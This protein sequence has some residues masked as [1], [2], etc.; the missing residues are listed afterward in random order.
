MIKT[1]ELP[2]VGEFVIIKIS[3]IMPHGAYCRITEYNIDSYLPI[4]EVSSG[5][6]KNIHEFIKEGQQ[7]VAK[8]IFTD[9]EKKSVDIS[10]K[11]A[12]SKAKKDKINE[13][14][15]EKRAEGMFNKA[16]ISSKSED[17]KQAIIEELSKLATTYNEIINSISDGK[18]PLAGIQEKDFKSALYELVAK[19][20]KPK[21]YT[22]SYNV[23]LTTTDTKSGIN[24]IKEALSGIEKAG[25]EVLYMGAPKYRFLA[26]DSSYPEAEDKIKHAQ[27]ILEKYKAIEFNMKSIKVQA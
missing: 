5:W 26:T 20:I 27:D 23:E 17:K 9:K 11:K 10:L 25:V 18:D 14:G 8:V 4:S 16:L 3:K 6:I 15:L 1:K 13:F 24:L 22:V 19:T 7:D 12:T 2:D 21:T